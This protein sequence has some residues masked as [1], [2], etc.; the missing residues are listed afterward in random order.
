VRQGL[1]SLVVEDV[2]IDFGGLKALDKV[3]LRVDSGE[4][5]GFIG[6]NG[7]G[8]TTLF[9]VICGFYRFH[10]GGVYLNGCMIHGLTPDA[11]AHRGIG[12]TFQAV[13]PFHNLSVLEN[14]LVP[15]GARRFS[16]RRAMLAPVA[17][18]GNIDK[19]RAIVALCG[20]NNYG[21]HPAGA[22]PLGLLRNLEIARVLALDA[23]VLLLDEPFSGLNAEEANSQKE[24]IRE[25]KAQ[26]KAILLIEHNVEIAMELCD[27]LVVLN[28]G[29][30]IAE[31][32]PSNVRAN[33]AVIEAYLGREA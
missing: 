2:S 13:R 17:E 19:A 26:G 1:C 33:P 32:L 8:K 12:R 7:A 21:E 31:G 18:N 6:P 9:N 14:V 15:Y 25:L 3:S 11:I 24:L 5:L 16:G 30:Q 10:S 23:Q 20:L 29:R 28:F 4:I 22:L 27:R